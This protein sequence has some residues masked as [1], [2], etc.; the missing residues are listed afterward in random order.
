MSEIFSFAAR[1]E[2]IR[3]VSGSRAVASTIQRKVISG[4]LAIAETSRWLFIIGTRH[5]PES[6]AQRAICLANGEYLRYNA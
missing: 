4:Q 6:S 3:Y 1:G 2:E 5:W